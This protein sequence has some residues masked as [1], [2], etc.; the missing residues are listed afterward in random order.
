MN[1]TTGAASNVTTNLTSFVTWCETFG[2]H[3]ILELPAEID[4]PSTAAY[5][6]SYTERVLAFHPSYW[7]I[8][9]E[10]AIWTH[11]EIPWSEWNASQAQN[12]T[13]EQ[14]AQ[15]V[16][17]YNIAIHSVDPSAPI[18]GLGGVGT[19]AFAEAEC[20]PDGRRRQRPEPDR[21]GDPRL[22]GRH[23]SERDGDPHAVLFQSD[24]S[25]V[26]GPSGSRRTGRPC[27]PGVRP[28][29]GSSSW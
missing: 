11:F 8:G 12:A 3:A 19:G 29:P 13:P 16:P 27:A 10:P 20:D 26:P 25:P 28:A 23:P 6:V 17:A 22:P 21:G 14:F 15:V 7:E 24:G 5:D 18:I 4:D 2:C 9:N 1:A